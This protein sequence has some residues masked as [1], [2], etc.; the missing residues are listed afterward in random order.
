M[1]T[2]IIAARDL[3]AGQRINRI[4]ADLE[5]ELVEVGEVTAVQRNGRTVAYKV[6]PKAWLE[7]SGRIAADSRLKHLAPF[8]VTVRD[9]VE[10][11]A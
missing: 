1:Q 9:R 7:D 4:N 10:A 2:R 3:H 6:Y 8:T 5:P 11:E